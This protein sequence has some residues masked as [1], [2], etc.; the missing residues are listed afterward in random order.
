MLHRYV[1]R[2]IGSTVDA[3]DVVQETLLKAYT[4]LD[5]LQPDSNIEQWLFR[6]AHNKAIDSLRK[7]RSE[8]VELLDEVASAHIPEQPLE[9]RELTRMA[10]GALIQLTPRQRSCV[11]LKDVLDHSLAEISE[12]LNATVPEIKAV[13]HR[14]RTR[15]REL[16]AEMSPQLDNPATGHSALSVAQ[17]ALVGNYADLFNKR[18]FEGLR[19]MLIDEVRL[20]LVGRIKL[21]G[22]EAVSN[23]Y[24]V[25]YAGRQDWRMAPGLVEG[26]PVVLVFELDGKSAAQSSQP[27]Y[28]IDLRWVDARVASIRDYR[29]ARYVMADVG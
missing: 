1:A 6:I 12:L 22:R 26:R 15:L 20:N 25:N 21:S 18:D 19:A 16:A 24:F 3:E 8:P 4:A 14:G 10:L 29:Y 23:N 17:L 2:M 13:L 5:Q 9:A 11:I 28:F 7:G 27:S